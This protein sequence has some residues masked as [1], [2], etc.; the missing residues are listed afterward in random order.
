M[1]QKLLVVPFGLLSLVSL[2]AGCGNDPAQPAG[3]GKP[4]RPAAAPADDDHDHGPAHPLGEIELAGHKI[5]VT[6]FG[7]VTPGAEMSFDLDFPAGQPL[8][9][10]LRGWLGIESAVGSRKVRFAKETETRMHGH[11]EVPKALPDGSRFWLE[12]EGKDG[13]VRGSLAYWK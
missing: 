10:A 8:P 6:Q 7:D 4:A 5:T 11:P 2:L 9:E 13:V 1:K 12:L 3:S